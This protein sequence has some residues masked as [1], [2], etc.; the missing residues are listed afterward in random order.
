MPLASVCL[1]AIKKTPNADYFPSLG[2]YHAPE[3]SKV[4]RER[5]ITLPAEYTKLV[6]MSVSK[7]KKLKSALDGICNIYLPANDLVGSYSRGVKFNTQTSR[8]LLPG[9]II[10]FL[11][12]LGPVKV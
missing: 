4:G 2:L 8:L 12:D 9:T 1:G 6:N 11:V 7:L 5:K 3:S 10:G